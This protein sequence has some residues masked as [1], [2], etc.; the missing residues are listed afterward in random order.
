MEK[1]NGIIGYENIKYELER[2]IDYLNNQEKY[3]KF[4]VSKPDNIIFV[5][6]PGLGKTKMANA[7]INSLN[8]K[9]YVI[10][11][12][13]SDGDFISE[14]EVKINEAIKN[15]PSVVLYDD[16]DKYS[17][18]DSNHS[19]TAEFIIIQ[20]M[21]DKCKDKDIFFIATANDVNLLPNSLQRSGRFGNSIT[22]LPPS[23]DESKEIIKYYLKGKKVDDNL[24][25]LEIAKLL[26]EGSCAT[27]EKVM[28]E[29]GL[30]AAF[31]NKDIISM[32]DIVKASLRIIYDSPM[33]FDEKLEE[34][35][36]VAAYHEAG[37]AIVSEVLEKNSVNI[38]SIDN[39][40]KNVGGVTCITKADDYWVNINKMENRIIMLLGG[41]AAIDIIFNKADVGAGS[42][43]KR[44]E[45]IL[46]RFYKSYYIDGFIE[47][48]LIEKN[49]KQRLT[50]YY[51]MAR[52][53]LLNNKDKLV[54]VSK[55]LIN[56]KLLTGSELRNLLID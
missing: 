8:R 6:E 34:E 2:V 55:L 24:D 26:N 7:F 3:Q 21:I 27:L 46:K 15:A 53:I 47:D 30:I 49:M 22:F 9:R 16:I 17:N 1:F 48:E 29:A 39:Y 36:M 56:K 13:K 44:A 52:D 25:Y 10:N 14:L 5:G 45:A 20:S 43:I 42:D 31:N 33:G 37:H 51:S 11:K 54:S 40:S 12:N 28:N 4:G 38:I 23:L 18:S 41:K 19:N 50:N 32:D 35:K